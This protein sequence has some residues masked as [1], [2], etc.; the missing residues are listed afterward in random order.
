MKKLRFI[1]KE[2]AELRL[3]LKEQPFEGDYAPR[4]IKSPMFGTAALYPSNS[5]ANIEYRCV[6]YNDPEKGWV[7]MCVCPGWQGLRKAAGPSKPCVHIFDKLLRTPT[8][9]LKAEMGETEVAKAKK[10][11]T[12][13]EKKAA[14][15]AALG[16]EPKPKKKAADGPKGASIRSGEDPSPEGAMKL[17]ASRYPLLS[18]CPASNAQEEGLIIRTTSEAAALGTIVHEAAEKMIGEQLEQPPDMTDRLEAM[19]INKDPWAKDCRILSWAAYR[20]WNG[21]PDSPV[22][23]LR[24][25]FATVRLEERFEHRM[26]VENPHT[27]KKVIVVTTAR[28]D[29]HGA[30]HEE[31]HWLI[32]DWKT[33]RKE[34]EPFY[35]AQM[36]ANAVAIMANDK[37]IHK[38]STI[39][40][41]LRHKPSATNPSIQ[42]YSRE[43]LV[44]WLQDIVRRRMF[45]DGKTHVTG[46]HCQYC[47][48]VYICEGRKAEF[49]NQMDILGAKDTDFLLYDDQGTLLVVEEILRR[50]EV[51]KAFR[52]VDKA[53]TKQVK[54]M[55]EESG[56]RPLAGQDGYALGLKEKKGALK[57]DVKMAWPLI[58]Q[59]LTVEQVS[60][61][62]SIS[63]GSL[64]KAVKSA[65]TQCETCGGT[66]YTDEVKVTKCPNCEGEGEVEVY[67]R[68]AKGEAWKELLEELETSG[69]AMRGK[70][71]KEISVIQL[72]EETVE[73][74]DD[75]E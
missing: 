60:P 52:A 31:G 55:L 56:P 29:L 19:G 35:E 65:M 9:D 13:A 62:L 6:V 1:S 15:K 20:M 3:K 67:P 43:E 47:P 40:P 39:I 42:T 21:A 72:D 45:W 38:V 27:K 51:C 33:N 4:E 61:A 75:D 17:W 70:P 66:G 14:A 53:F 34:N 32:V 48:R 11:A 44:E 16:V 30:S 37:S 8:F 64:E 25:Y 57:I 68:G 58:M 49:R 73:E 50:L 71:S 22:H 54:A 23:P 7:G 12:L 5:K 41:W 24:E 26:R 59:K 36:L 74:E 10:A 18:V 63:K 2:V 69:A 28:I 46:D